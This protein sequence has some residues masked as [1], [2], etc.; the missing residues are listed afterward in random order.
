MCMIQFVLGK[1]PV[2]QS[3]SMVGLARLDEDRWWGRWGRIFCT[4]ACSGLWTL[5]FH[6][7]FLL[8]IC[9]FHIQKIFIHFFSVIS[10]LRIAAY[11][12]PECTTLAP[13]LFQTEDNQ[14]PADWGRAF[15]L[16][17][18][19]LQCGKPGLD[20][21]VGKIPWRREWQPTPVFLPGE[22][23]EQRNLVG[24][25]VHEIAES[26]MTEQLTHAHN[27]LKESR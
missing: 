14:G 20:N 1:T 27:C 3:G 15:C 23:Y 17:L 18:N 10:F 25:T 4:V 9:G 8:L 11:A 21:W 13:G 2:G 16:P 24:Y 22:F 6:P 5:G 12:T 19:Y 7:V 26:D